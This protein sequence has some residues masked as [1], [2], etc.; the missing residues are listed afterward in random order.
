MPELIFYFD[1]VCPY[2]YLASTKIEDLAKK[3]EIKLIWRP[4]LLG[5]IYKKLKAPQ[6]PAK[7]WPVSKI[8]Y[9]TMDLKRQAEISGVPLEKPASHPMRTVEAMRLLCACPENK[10]TEMAHRLY[11]AYW[12]HG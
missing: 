8:K 12:V 6:V 3:Y 10:I 4:V 7:V 11:Q 2:A 1:V 9:G 5:G